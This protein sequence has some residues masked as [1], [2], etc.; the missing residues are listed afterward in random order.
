M[1]LLLTDSATLKSENDLDL[2]IFSCFGTVEEY[3]CLS[4]SEVLEKV[5]DVDIILCNKT[6]ID[7]EVL[8]RAKKLRYIGLFA[9][10]Y[11]NI[12]I[13][14]ADEFGVTVANAGSYST[15]AVAQQVFA[16]ILNHYS[17]IGEYNSFVRA[18]GW[19][20]SPNFSVLC[21][22]TDELMGKT[23]GIIGY[24]SIAKR[25]EQIAKAF[26]MN[27]LVYT[28][29]PKA[30]GFTKFVDL[31][32]L[33]ANSDIV[34]VHC[35]L[36]SQSEKMFNKTAF[37]KMKQSTYFINTAR[38]GVV[39]EE[40]LLEAL[41]CGKISGAAVD[42]LNYEPMRKDCVLFGAPNLVITPHTAWAP[43]ATRLRLLEI[44][45]NNIKAF[46]DG[47]PQNVV[48]NPQK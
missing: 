8:K 1:K 37:G 10:G 26:Q 21:Y 48:N 22:P 23:I 25:V 20:K 31:D 40:A 4:H 18:G 5:S 45:K 24:G 15:S 43:L 42:V 34:S 14:A 46:L 7:R 33:L 12:D 2:N 16:Y 30:N 39:D 44:V 19:Q 41:C 27:V 9:T 35:P 28:R 11:N 47:K 36:N 13:A 17:K 32:Y 29:T 6:V 38:G 3:D